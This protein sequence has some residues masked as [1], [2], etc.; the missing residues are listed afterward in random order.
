M[1][2]H[3]CGAEVPP[4]SKFCPEC[5]TNLGHAETSSSLT[6]AERLR[7]APDSGSGDGDEVEKELWE[8][9][10]S[11]KAMIGSWVL[12]GVIT[13][14]LL[15]G[16]IA[17]G[18]LGPVIWAIFG[19]I[20]LLMWGY[21]ACLLAYRKLSVRYELTTQRF[22]HMTGILRRTTD[23]IEVIDIDDVTY[24]QGFV[25]RMLG[26][27]TV[28]INSSDRTHP[29]LSLIGIDDVIRIADLID[30]I[31]RKERRRRGLHIEAI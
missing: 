20:L 8:G 3:S 16:M 7:N 23:R 10:Y 31:R 9:G 14:V 29:E 18:L 12:A 5:G 26:V 22:I 24:V 30:D 2:C 28:K 17:A 1:H 27:G 11:G 25:Q 21:L 15:V 4:E 13:V 6:P 19:A